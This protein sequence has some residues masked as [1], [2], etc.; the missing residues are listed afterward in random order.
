MSVTSKRKIESNRRNAQASTGPKTVKGRARS[1][2]N[3]LRYGLS[4]PVSADADLSEQIEL[5]TEE[6]AESGANAETL[7]RARQFAEAQTEVRRVR[8]IRHQL[9]SKALSEPYYGS[10]ADVLK[11]ARLI[12]R[13]LRKNAPEFF[14]TERTSMLLF[15]AMPK[16]PER[17]ATILCE[18]AKQLDALDR[19]E[20]RALSR[21]KFA[22]R[23]LDAARREADSDCQ[24]TSAP[25][26]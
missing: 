15:S 22:I 11:K 26:A 20:R 8:Y 23:A 17:T 1:A 5:L 7:E 10:R 13:L 4:L 2:R 18:V 19:Y 12:G 6:I 3:A 24:G 21:R 9:L 16:G 25:S 14:I